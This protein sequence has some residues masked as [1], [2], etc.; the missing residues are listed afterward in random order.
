MV[1]VSKVFELIFLNNKGFLVILFIAFGFVTIFMK[2]RQVWIV[3]WIGGCRLL[4]LAN[5][6]VY[7]WEEK[8]IICIEKY[9]T[10]SKWVEVNFEGA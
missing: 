6:G 7:S 5:Y 2:A 3:W 4:L 1:A 10:K 9:A 8:E